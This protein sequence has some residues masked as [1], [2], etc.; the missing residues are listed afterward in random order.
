MHAVS[1]VRAKKVIGTDFPPGHH[2]LRYVF[3]KFL[4]ID[5]AEIYSSA[6][7]NRIKDKNGKD[8]K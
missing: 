5:V 2:P 7:L 1:D 6:K 8:Q 3:F 4:P